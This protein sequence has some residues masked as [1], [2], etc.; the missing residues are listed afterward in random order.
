MGI[1]GG[2][3]DTARRAGGDARIAQQD[4]LVVRALRSL[5]EPQYSRPADGGR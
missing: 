4:Q 5:R 2:V 3:A 1:P